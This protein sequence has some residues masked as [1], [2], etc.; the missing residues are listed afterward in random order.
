MSAIEVV[1]L[2]I[3]LVLL[4]VLLVVR[5]RAQQAWHAVRKRRE[6]V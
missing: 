2:A 5:R 6:L 4:I 1:L 3:N